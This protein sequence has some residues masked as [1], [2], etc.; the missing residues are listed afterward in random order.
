MPGT[1][2]GEPFPHFLLLRAF[3]AA[4][5][6]DVQPGTFFERSQ[7]S[8]HPLWLFELVFTAFNQLKLN[9]FAAIQHGFGHFEALIH[10]DPCVLLPVDQ[11]CGCINGASSINRRFSFQSQAFGTDIGNICVFD[12]WRYRLRG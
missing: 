4:S 1:I 8:I 11:Q 5:V 9:L 7:A 2:N 12:A 10:G 6:S 3:Q